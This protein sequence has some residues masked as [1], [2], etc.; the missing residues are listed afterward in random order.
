VFVVPEEA[1]TIR[2]DISLTCSL[3]SNTCVVTSILVINW[4]ITPSPCV[5]ASVKK[6][7]HVSRGSKNASGSLSNL[8]TE[9]RI[10]VA[11]VLKRKLKYLLV[12]IVSRWKFFLLISVISYAMRLHIFTVSAT[13]FWHVKSTVTVPAQLGKAKHC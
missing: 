11:N 6:S 7:L 8:L 10:I 9:I 13:I 3:R 12:P 4:L 2:R 5:P 1:D